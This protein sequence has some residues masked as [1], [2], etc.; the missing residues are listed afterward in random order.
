ML[1]VVSLYCYFSGYLTGF[2][3][4]QGLMLFI[5]NN[6]ICFR[7]VA[8]VGEVLGD[9]DEIEFDDLARLKYMGQ[10]DFQFY[11]LHQLTYHLEPC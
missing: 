3:W 5:M 10:V 1:V 6:L 2:I 11:F 4:Q 7:L 8:E 9:K